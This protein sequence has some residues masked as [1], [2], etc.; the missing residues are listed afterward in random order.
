MNHQVAKKLNASRRNVTHECQD[1]G[2]KFPSFISLSQHKFQRKDSK[3]VME[4]QRIL[5]A[6]M[7]EN[8]NN[9]SLQ[10]EM[11]A[12]KRFLVVSKIEH[13]RIKAI[14]YAKETLSMKIVE[15]KLDQLFEKLYSWAMVNRTFGF[16]LRN[17]E[18]SLDVYTPTKTIY[19]ST[20][21]RSSCVPELTRQRSKKF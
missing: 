6:L 10:E 21:Y 11:Q 7:I 3:K 18:E 15:E 4:H 16:I 9:K 8:N 2:E 19:C 17:I 1:C 14:N 13:A 12:Y 20:Y 5:Q